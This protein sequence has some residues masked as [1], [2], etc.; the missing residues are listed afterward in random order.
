MIGTRVTMGDPRQRGAAE[1]IREEVRRDVEQALHEARQGQPGLDESARAA[2]ERAAARIEAEAGGTGGPRVQ[3]NVQSGGPRVSVHPMPPL[4]PAPWNGRRGAGA[5][6]GPNGEPEFST[7]TGQPPAFPVEIPPQAVDIAVAFFFT[8]AAV[9]I[10]T[11]LARAY[12]RRMDRKGVAGPTAGPEVVTRLDRIEQAVDAIALEV[13]RISEGQRYVTKLMA[14]QRALPSADGA[15]AAEL[16]ALERGL[17]QRA[18]A[19]AERGT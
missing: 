16:G 19:A 5:G 14:E 6:P 1:Q 2:L 15:A 18:P 13:E 12:A 9:F 3:V 11:P 4:P 7:G 8:I 17:A 10:G